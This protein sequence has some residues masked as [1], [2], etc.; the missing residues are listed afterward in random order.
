MSKH[1]VII[2]WSADDKA[3]LAEVPELPGF[4]ARFPNPRDRKSVV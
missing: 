1:E 4:A 3:F 2:Y